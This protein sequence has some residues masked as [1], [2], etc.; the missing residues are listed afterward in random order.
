[1]NTHSD[2][3]GS[4]FERHPRLTIAVLLVMAIILL[5]LLIANAFRLIQGY[6]W[7]AWEQAD[8]IEKSYRIKSDVFNHTL[9]SNH[10]IDNAVWG[11][12]NYRVRINSL[13]FRDRSVRDIDPSTE[14]H[15]IL[16]IGDSFTEGMG[17]D[18]ENT[19]V[20]RISES[21]S[22]EGIEVLNTAASSYSPIIYWRKIKYLIE[23][24]GLR[25]SE[26]V[27]FLDIS[28]ADD[29]AVVY[30]LD[31][32][33]NVRFQEGY[34]IEEE[35]AET[36]GKAF[37][38]FL[39]RNS[40][41]YGWLGGIFVK[42]EETKDRTSHKYA[43]N[44]YRALWTSDDAL[45][46]EYGSK[47]LESM[48]FYMNRLYELLEKNNIKLM[49]A[50]Y[51]WPDQIRNG[52]LRPRPVSFWEDWCSRKEVEFID[53]FPAFMDRRAEK[54]WQWV[55]DEYYIPGDIHWNEEGHSLIAD[56]FLHRYGNHPGR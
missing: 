25:F 14:A 52:E 23:T 41:I 32:A 56:D 19:F 30:R 40:I 20:G 22:E 44:C 33:G 6:P 7:S 26:V 31:N 55:L 35:L 37:G 36:P 49:V 29:E 9:A 17:V 50:V 1:M 2:K 45:F 47:G 48:E 53:I 5:D 38:R 27:V 24:T 54:G 4:L 16:F 39:S 15:R 11:D 34:I 43:L 42:V 8:L 12:R 28:D 21:L 13:G 18:W 3:P 46:D 10:S 51:P